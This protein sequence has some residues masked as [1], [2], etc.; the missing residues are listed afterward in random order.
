MSALGH[1]RTWGEHSVE[2]APND[3]MRQIAKRSATLTCK[4]WQDQI[5]EFLDAEGANK[6]KN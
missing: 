6:T 2:F 4:F 3:H 5:M 1:K